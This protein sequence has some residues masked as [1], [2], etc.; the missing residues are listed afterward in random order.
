MAESSP[1][2]EHPK[3]LTDV[4]ALLQVMGAYRYANR[5]IENWEKTIGRPPVSAKTWTQVM[6][7][8]PEFFRLKDGLAILVWRRSY[9]KSFDPDAGKAYTAEELERIESLPEEQ[10]PSLTRQALTP[11]QITALIESAIKIHAA[12]IAY[13]Q[14]LRWR[15]PVLAGILGVLLGAV[16]NGYRAL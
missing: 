3:R 14:E 4:I 16:L 15:V 2:I 12:A 1:Y 11:D 8:H 5:K 13:S 6:T 10:Q 7:D 9:D